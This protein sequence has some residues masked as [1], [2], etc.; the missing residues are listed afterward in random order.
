MVRWKLLK[1]MALILGIAA[2]GC[3]ALVITGSV[4][5]HESFLSYG[6]DAYTGIQNAAA[7]TANNVMYLGETI[8]LALAAFL[9]LQGL[10]LIFGSLCIR[11]KQSVANIQPAPAPVAPVAPVAPA[12]PVF[13]PP[14][15]PV[16]PVQPAPAPWTCPHCGTGNEATYLFCQGCGKSK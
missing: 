7:Q 4:G 15:Q 5:Y 3:A 9:A 2:L 10:L 12:T 11:T 13:T 1:V 16:Q 14:V 6:G 8:R